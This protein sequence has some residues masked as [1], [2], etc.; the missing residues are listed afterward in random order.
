VVEF[1]VTR[2]EGY[3]FLP[4]ARRTRLAGQFVTVAVPTVAREVKVPVVTNVWGLTEV[5]YWKISWWKGATL[6]YWMRG[7]FK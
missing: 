7:E 2:P 6:I 3:N 5:V 1:A 4:F